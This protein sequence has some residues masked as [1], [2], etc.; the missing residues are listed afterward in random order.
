[1]ELLKKIF[2][3]PDP[4]I[5]DIPLFE[6]RREIRCKIQTPQFLGS[7]DKFYMFKQYGVFDTVTLKFTPT[8]IGGHT[9][10]FHDINDFYNKALIKYIEF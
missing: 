5:L 9:V 6:S 4:A 7:Q 2:N 1:M 8:C 3:R 10:Q